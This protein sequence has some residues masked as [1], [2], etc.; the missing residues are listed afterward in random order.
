[1][2]TRL[3]CSLLAKIKFLKCKILGSNNDLNTCESS[4]VR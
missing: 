1:M 4:D 2:P 3:V